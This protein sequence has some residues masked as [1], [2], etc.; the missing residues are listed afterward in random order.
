M[1]AQ[2]FRPIRWLIL[3]VLTL[4]VSL[5]ALAEIAKDYTC[6]PEGARW[7]YKNTVLSEEYR[8]NVNK[9]GYWVRQ[10]VEAL[11]PKTVDGRDYQVFRRTYVYANSTSANTYLA[12]ANA[13][14]RVFTAGS[15]DKAGKVTLNSNPFSVLASPFKAGQTWNTDSPSEAFPEYRIDYEVISVGESVTVPTGT[16][17]KC[18]HL[19]YKMHVLDK[20]GRTTDSE[21]HYYYAAG[22][23]LLKERIEEWTSDKGGGYRTV[24]EG[25]LT[26][27][28]PSPKGWGW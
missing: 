22:T 7:E 13:E 20:S 25:V 19:K 18:V 8:G 16:H 1:K 12:F 4:M 3:P 28:V 21:G 23:G 2:S 15:I 17:Q 9:V 14:G 10:T 11:A 6:Y 5:T 24:R 26:K 27:Y